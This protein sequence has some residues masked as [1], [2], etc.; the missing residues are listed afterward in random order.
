M[1]LP[2]GWQTKKLSDVCDI[3]SSKR[4]Y[5]REYVAEGIPFYRGKEIIQ[6]AKNKSIAKTLYILPERYQEIKQK[7]GVPKPGDILL[8]S[9]GTLGVPYVV[10]DSDVFYFKDGNL[11]WFKNYSDDV[12][13]VFLYY[14]L[15]SHQMK[16]QVTASHIGVAQPALTI[17]GLKGFKIDLPFLPTQRKI[18][19][20]L[21]AYDDLIE[22]NTRRIALLE[23]T[24]QLLYRE[25]FVHFRFPGHESV[26]LVE[27]ELGAIPEEWEV[28][29]IGDLYATSSG[30]TPSR[31]VNEYFGGE[32]NWIKTRELKDSFIFDTEEKI[33]ALGL[34]KSSAKLFPTNTVVIAMYGATIGQLGILA[35]P[36]ATNQACCALLPKIPPFD[37][38][39]AFLCLLQNRSDLINL[40]M[41]AAQQNISQQVIKGY[42]ILEPSKSIVHRFND[43]V[44]PIFGQ[45]QVLKRKNQTLRRTR[46][47][48]LPRLISGQLD[49]SELEILTGEFS[50]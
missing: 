9:V 30:G 41:G 5:R 34:Q 26:P 50:Q 47:L 18:A 11:T 36:S 42:Q 13:N 40:R 6:K 8:T 12:C 20:I 45:V 29:T 21:S 24:A 3:S 19:A 39:Y 37:H 43:C 14:W 16:D 48:L 38:R 1:R 17:V 46:D 23:Q 28:A 2:N 25:W 35:S 33:T 7:Y 49:V 32:V 22:N 44:E 15:L 27:S 4:I 31:K 10:K